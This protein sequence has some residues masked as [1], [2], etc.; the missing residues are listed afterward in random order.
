M[1]PS[2]NSYKEKTAGGLVMKKNTGIEHER[3]TSNTK[4]FTGGLDG[5][6]NIPCQQ[7]NVDK[8][9]ASES[10]AAFNEEHAKLINQN[11]P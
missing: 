7:E 3:R 1:G 11:K 2:F 10:I 9:K 6:R 4:T 5:S 8:W